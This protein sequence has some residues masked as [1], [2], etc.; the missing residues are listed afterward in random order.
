MMIDEV[1]EDSRTEVRGLKETLNVDRQS[2]INIAGG[3]RDDRRGGRGGYGGGGG[4]GGFR[5]RG[6]EENHN[7][8]GMRRDRRDSDR[9]RGPERRP[10]QQEEFREATAG[11]YFIYLYLSLLIVDFNL[12]F[13]FF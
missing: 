4:G 5:D 6:G 3:Y 8:F 11:R 2:T 1:A 12:L 7:N 9:E 10:R 13:I